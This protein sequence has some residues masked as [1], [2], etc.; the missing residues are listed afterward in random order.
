MQQAPCAERQ[1][2]YGSEMTASDFHCFLPRIDEIVSDIFDQSAASRN[3]E[4]NRPN[5]GGE[6]CRCSPNVG[7]LDAIVD[8]PRR[9]GPAEL[10]EGHAMGRTAAATF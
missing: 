7:E 6:C 1:R 10:A 2:A 3:S 8:R 9:A 4:D 5:A